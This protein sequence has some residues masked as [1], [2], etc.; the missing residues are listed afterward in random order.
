MQNSRYAL[1]GFAAVVII[2]GLLAYCNMAP[3]KSEQPQ[4]APVAETAPAE[5]P[6]AKTEAAPE[7]KTEAPAETKPAEPEKQAAA[8][9]VT[10]PVFDVLRLEGDGS[11]VIA[12]K[13]APNS[14]VDLL[15]KTRVLGSAKAGEN[16]DFAIVLDQAL[17]S[18]DYQLVLRAT[19]GENSVATSQQTAIL[20]V[21]ATPEGQV[22]ALVEEPGQASRM[23]TTPQAAPT[24][25]QP[26]GSDVPVAQHGSSAPYSVLPPQNVQGGSAGQDAK[27]DVSIAVEAVE[28]EGASVFIAGHARG[29]QTVNISANELLLGTA[30]ITPEGRYLVQTQQPLAV[31]DYII[32]ADLMDKGGKVLATAR[33]PFRR[34]EGENIAAVAPSAP[35]QEEVQA[36]EPQPLEEAEGS[37]IIRKGD[38]LWTISKRTYGSGLRYTTIYLS[39]RDQIKNPDLIWPGQVFVMPKEPLKDLDVQQKL[40]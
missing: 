30:I 26:E 2:G 24:M 36:A 18:G 21:P 27:S 23:I 40:P 38:N 14:Q 6:E 13:A 28:I 4:Q 32:R 20:S 9:T 1:A 31:G 5:K 33:V 3:K 16:G 15:S 39:N 22:L 12:G 17:K 25:Q 19:S 7:V 34:V 10:V 8:Q 11:L 35:V 37:V 29:G